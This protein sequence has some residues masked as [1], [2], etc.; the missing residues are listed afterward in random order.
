[1]KTYII[2]LAAGNSK[3]FP[4]NKLLY[5]FGDKPLYRHTFDQLTYQLEN[6]IVVTQYREIGSCI[7]YFRIYFIKVKNTRNQEKR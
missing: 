1:M 5:R 2:Y 7:I 6:I 3:R 4:D